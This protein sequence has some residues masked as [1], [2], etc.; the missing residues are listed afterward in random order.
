MFGR[1]PNL[2]A[3]VNL[4]VDNVNFDVATP[5]TYMG[6]VKS[7]LNVVMAEVRKCLATSQDKMAQQYNKH[8]HYYDYRAGNKVWLRKKN[9]RIGESM[10]LSP[11][12][13]GT[14]QIVEVLAN[15]LNYRIRLN[16]IECI[17][18]HNRLSPLR[19]K[20]IGPRVRCTA[21]VTQSSSEIDSAGDSDSESESE[22]GPGGMGSVPTVDQE[23]APRRY[24]ERS[25]RPT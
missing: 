11:R 5:T 18:H 1:K 21:P 13:T 24:P 8:L 20:E 2:P 7:K 6:K 25:R 12:R 15:G 19:S 14:W 22:S 23:S 4:D 3:D 10:K 17:V 16:D 9:Y